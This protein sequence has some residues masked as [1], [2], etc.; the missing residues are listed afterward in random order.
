MKKPRADFRFPLVSSC[1][2]TSVD[3]PFSLFDDTHRSR[4]SRTEETHLYILCREKI[5]TLW[6]QFLFWYTMIY[7]IERKVKKKINQNKNEYPKPPPAHTISSYK[8]SP[9]THTDLQTATRYTQEKKRTA[10]KTNEQMT[11]VILMIKSC[12]TRCK[13]STPFTKYD[14]YE[15]WEPFSSQTNGR[16]P[17]LLSSL[18]LLLFS[19]HII[20]FYFS[21]S[22]CEVL[23]MK[24]LSGQNGRD[25][26]TNID[27]PRC[28]LLLLQIRRQHWRIV[29]KISHR[30]A[31]NS[32]DPLR[33]ATRVK[34]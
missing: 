5:A 16:K 8:T 10:N 22:F 28:K 18:P 23:A 6:S 30:T 19:I 33:K 12:I 24:R 29:H 34:F 31:N 4:H 1:Y 11:R 17:I 32:P 21:I 27:F 3:S 14:R 13:R 15:T 20:L 25:S 9:K 26:W 7:I 2:T